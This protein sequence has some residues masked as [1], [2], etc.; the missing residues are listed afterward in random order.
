MQKIKKG[1]FEMFEKYFYDILIEFIKEI[2]Y[3]NLLWLIFAILVGG[4]GIFLTIQNRKKVRERFAPIDYGERKEKRK[5]E[6]TRNILLDESVVNKIKEDDEMFDALAFKEWVKETFLQFQKAYA[7]GDMMLVRNRVDINLC[8]CYQLLRKT[9][10][11]VKQFLE[12]LKI[13]YVDFSAYYKEVEKEIIE[14]AIN[15]IFSNNGV[16]NE[17]VKERT[18]YI[19]KFIRKKGSKS[20]NAM[21]E[22]HCPNCG[23]IVHFEQNH[24]EY[25]DS[26][27]LNREKD[28]ILNAIEK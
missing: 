13:N 24:C 28:W 9:D 22:L 4:F 23:A 12:I 6:Y 5:R 14:V 26:W 25:C 7:V 8:E 27:L 2:I 16:R 17:Q 20:E 11:D 18:T 21:K 10:P 1:K 15:C 19:L 3:E